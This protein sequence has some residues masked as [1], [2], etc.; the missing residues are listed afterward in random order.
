MALKE[1]LDIL[2]PYYLY[3]ARCR[4]ARLTEEVAVVIGEVSLAGPLPFEGDLDRVLG[5]IVQ[6]SKGSN[7]GFVLKKDSRS[8]LLPE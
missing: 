3:N 8:L 5:A 2:L 6:I 7:R 1:A 4:G